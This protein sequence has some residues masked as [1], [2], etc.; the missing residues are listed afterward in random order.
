MTE[1]DIEGMCGDDICRA[2][3]IA[4]LVWPGDPLVAEPCGQCEDAATAA[5]LARQSD[6]PRAV[7]PERG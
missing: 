2:R 1:D 6:R 4:R 7:H 3:V 5:L